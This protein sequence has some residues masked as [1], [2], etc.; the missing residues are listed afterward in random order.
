[1]RA[2]Q[3]TLVAASVSNAVEVLALHAIWHLDILFQ[4]KGLGF[5]N[6]ILTPS[7]LAKKTPTKSHNVSQL[8]FIEDELK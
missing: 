3:L 1:M 2:P 8:S 7:Y 6:T 4:R 5:H